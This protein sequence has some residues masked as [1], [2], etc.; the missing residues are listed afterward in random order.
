MHVQFISKTRFV[1]CF[2]CIHMCI[3]VG[4]WD[5]MTHKS[6]MEI[7]V[8]DYGCWPPFKLVGGRWSICRS[9]NCQFW[10]SYEQTPPVPA[11]SISSGPDHTYLCDLAEISCR[12]FFYQMVLGCKKNKQPW[13]RPCSLRTTLLSVS[14][15]ALCWPLGCGYCHSA[16]I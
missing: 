10:G 14:T 13:Q 9:A 2:I 1:K 15:S 4:I 6:R 7:F 8:L 5:L 3:K 16:F 11:L 12:L